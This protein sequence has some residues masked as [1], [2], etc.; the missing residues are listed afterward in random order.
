MNYGLMAKNRGVEDGFVIR[1]RSDGVNSRAIGGPAASRKAIDRIFKACRRG[2]GHRHYRCR[3][4]S[5]SPLDREN[6]GTFWPRSPGLIEG[7]VCGPVGPATAQIDGQIGPRLAE[8]GEVGGG[9]PAPGEVE[10]LHPREGLQR[11][12]PLGGDAVEFEPIVEGP[13]LLHRRQALQAGVR[14]PRVR[15]IEQ[16]S[17]PGNAAGMSA[18]AS[19][20]TSEPVSVRFLTDLEGGRSRKA[21]AGE[22]RALARRASPAS[23][24]RSIR[25]GRPGRSA[26]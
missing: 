10:I 7:T 17:R 8:F 9:V 24:G 20:G 23:A 3:A 21:S 6:R 18:S 22:P 5:P 11:G 26:T 19:S 12:Q 13:Q 14:D 16:V 2:V 1:R 25:R 15:Q 4:G